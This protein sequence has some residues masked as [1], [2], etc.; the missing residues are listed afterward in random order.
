MW[1]FAIGSADDCRVRFRTTL[2]PYLGINRALRMNRVPDDVRWQAP[3]QQV[4]MPFTGLRMMAPNHRIL[5]RR[6]VLGVVSGE[7][8][9]IT[10]DN[11]VVDQYRR[12]WGVAARRP[13]FSETKEPIY[14][15]CT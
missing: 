2:L 8:V 10:L 9:D 6:H 1:T 4:E 7:G 15:V 12:G 11:E 13:T 14:A 3:F 5:C